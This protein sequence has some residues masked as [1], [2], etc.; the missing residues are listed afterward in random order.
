MTPAKDIH[1][2]K[3]GY[4]L[5]KKISKGKSLDWVAVEKTLEYKSLTYFSLIDHR[6]GSKDGS[7]T[8]KGLQV[9]LSHQHAE[10]DR[11]EEHR[12][13]WLIAVFSTLGGAI[14][15]KPMWDGIDWLIEWIQE[16]P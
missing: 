1:L 14:L 13:N 6:C 12:H 4:R 3:N 2:S 5:L 15:S 7:L 9:L 11:K 10:E 8:E 16:I